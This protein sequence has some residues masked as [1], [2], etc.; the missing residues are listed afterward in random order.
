MLHWLRN[1]KGRELQQFWIKLLSVS[2]VAHALI[3]IT[4][5]FLYKDDSCQYNMTVSSKNLRGA[6][7]IFM[8][9]HKVVNAHR[10]NG[11]I[12]TG[13]GST[14]T[15]KVGLVSSVAVAGVEKKK[16]AAILAAAQEKK[17]LRA[18]KLKQ[19]KEKKEKLMLAAKKK[20]EAEKEQEALK[21]AEQK[22]REM[23]QEKEEALKLAAEEKKR[24][25]EKKE[26]LAK[27][28]L[29]VPQPQPQ[30]P[31]Q[32][33]AIP[34]AGSQQQGGE[35]AP[36]Y[37][38]QVE[39]EELDRQEELQQVVSQYWKPP[40]GLRDG[41]ECSLTFMVDA[42]GNATQVVVQ[43]TSGVLVYDMAARMAIAQMQL[44][45]W[46]RGKEL[47]ITFI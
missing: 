4:V 9:F 38:G 29:E 37:V 22:K 26:L 13:A 14:R 30:Q 23:Q 1:Q 31:E 17:K 18:Q 27:K 36:F 46:A 44:P 35:P 19:H 24:E 39:M 42:D 20:K 12:S 33:G 10:I 40:V 43:K 32:L 41:L 34:V 6:P 28:E 25:A 16:K 21:L 7:I 47:S 5:F 15:A 11:Q 8:P 45:S 3:L 2:L